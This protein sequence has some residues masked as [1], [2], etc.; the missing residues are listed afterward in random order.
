MV[1]EPTDR[2]L[3]LSVAGSLAGTRI[4]GPAYQPS[5]PPQGFY[6]GFAQGYFEAES[7]GRIGRAE[8]EVA[9]GREMMIW[10]SSFWLKPTLELPPNELTNGALAF[11]TN[12]DHRLPLT[13]RVQVDGSVFE[14][15]TRAK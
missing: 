3:L 9:E 7:Q 10:V 15:K 8:R 4:P 1:L 6:G 14:F 2:D 11:L 12:P 13:V 5:G